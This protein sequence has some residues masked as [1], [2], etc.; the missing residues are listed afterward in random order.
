MM[1]RTKYLK[2]IEVIVLRLTPTTAEDRPFGAI[3]VGAYQEGSLVS[4]GAVGTGYTLEQMR[5]IAARH[6]T[7][8]GQV[9]ITVA[10]QG[11]TETGQL[12]HGRFLDFNNL[13]TPEDCLCAASR[14]ATTL[15]PIT[16][17]KIPAQLELF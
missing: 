11:F 10:C 12:W 16:Q 9:V 14:A 6:T 5:E 13:V 17:T 7:T 2:E 3:E 15:P 8:P 4:L 1:V